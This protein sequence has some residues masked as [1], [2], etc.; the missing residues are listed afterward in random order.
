MAV[1]VVKNMRIYIDGYQVGCDANRVETQVRAEALDKTNFCSSGRKRTPG[2]L[3]WNVSISG[4]HNSSEGLVGS[5]MGR[6]GPVAYRTISLSSAVVSIVYG[7]SARGNR[8]Y[9]GKAGGAEYNLGGNIGELYGFTLAMSGNDRIVR[10]KL[11]EAGAFTTESKVGG[12]PTTFQDIGVSSTKTGQLYAALHMLS[13]TGGTLNISVRMSSE[14][15]MG[16]ATTMIKWTAMSATGGRGHF[17]TTKITS[18]K[19]RYVKV[20]G[21]TGSRGGVSLTGALLVGVLDKK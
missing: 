9:F 7:T 2:L 10:G 19:K 5:S 21:T 4:F 17:A 11:L 15:N 14:T 16:A 6:S 13:S 3:D 8:A 1:E 12:V 20:Y 18:T